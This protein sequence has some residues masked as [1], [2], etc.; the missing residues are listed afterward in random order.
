MKA[1]SEDLSR[2]S[3]PTD[4]G[5]VAQTRTSEEREQGAERSGEKSKDAMAGD[6]ILSLLGTLEPFTPLTREEAND[7]YLS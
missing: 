3:L 5:E 7:R 1:E 6:Y 4:E 2:D